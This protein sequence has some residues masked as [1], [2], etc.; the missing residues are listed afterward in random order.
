MLD[1][2]KYSVFAI[3]RLDSSK[4][5]GY[6]EHGEI[7]TGAI[8]NWLGTFI[9]PA[10]W[11]QGFG[12]EAKQLC[13]C[14]LFENYPLERVWSSTLRHHTRA[15]RGLEACGMAY[16]GRIRGCHPSIGKYFDEVLFHIF[17]EEWERLPI[18]DVVQRG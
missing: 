15:A 3:E 14:Y 18:R 11:H 16:E 6:E 4:L 2:G 12:V 13:M 9:L 8:N 5:V 7:E 1:A 10:H 17:R